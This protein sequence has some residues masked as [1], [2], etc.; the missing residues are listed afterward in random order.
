MDTIHKYPLQ[1]LDRQEIALPKGTTVLSVGTPQANE[2]NAIM[3]WARVDTMQPKEK[4]VFAIVGTGDYMPTGQLRF[5]GT[6]F[7]P[8]G[9]LVFHVFEILNSD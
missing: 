9:K 5:I 3:L 7:M 4:R 6:I 1:M 8:S 2:T